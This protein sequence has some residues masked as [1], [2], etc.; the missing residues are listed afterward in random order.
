MSTRTTDGVC[1]ARR[2]AR[3]AIATAAAL[4]ATAAFAA[5]PA[6]AELTGF[7]PIMPIGFPSYYEDANGLQLGLCI[8]DPGCPSSPSVLE[9]VAPNDEAFWFMAGAEVGDFNSATAPAV[10]V[11]F[12]VEAA[13][14]G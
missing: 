5:V 9:P 12:A 8:G 3:T 7:G 11:D 13:Y 1:T 10:R 2:P 6:Q 14:I 4:L